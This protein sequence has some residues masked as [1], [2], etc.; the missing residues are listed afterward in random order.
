[1]RAT[2]PDERRE[3]RSR[4]DDGAITAY[5]VLLLGAMMALLGLAFDGGLALSAHQ[6]AYTEAEQA[7]RAGAS[8]LAGWELRGGLVL[9][10]TGAA[11]EA[12][13]QFMSATGHPGVVTVVGD[14]VVATVLPYRVSSPLLGFAGVSSLTVSA[15]ASATA[16]AG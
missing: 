5:V 3:Y 7:A 9:P 14:R 1:M 16:I 2:E 4:R 13:E 8:A 11:I 15:S 6:A 10:A 12:A